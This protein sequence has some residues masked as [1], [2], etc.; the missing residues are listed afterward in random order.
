[1]SQSVL[2][3]YSRLRAVLLLCPAALVIYTASGCGHSQATTARG[4][5]SH[6]IPVRSFPVAEQKVRRRVQ[7]VGSLFA[8][9]ESTISAQVEGRIARVLV[10][11]GDTVKQGQ[12]MVE[13]DPV[14]LQYALEQQR[15]QVNQMRAQLG[16]GP[17]DPPPKDPGKV[18][19]VQRAAADLFDAEQKFHRAQQMFHDTLISQQQLD[20]AST[21]DQGAKAAYALALQDVDR[22]KAQLQSGQAGTQLAEKKLSDAS[23]R[24][25]F[26]GAVKARSVSPGEYLRVQSPVMVVVRTDKLRA[27]LAVPERWAGTVK[28]GAMIDV[29]VEAFPNEVFRG[30]L[31][32]MNPAV[33]QDS[34]TFD[35]EALLA[36]PGARLKPGFFVQASMPSEVEERTLTV[37]EQAVTY[38]YGTYKVFVL[39]GS[40]VSERSIKPGAQNDDGGIRRIEI[41]EGLTARDRVAVAIEGDLR[42]GAAVRDQGA[43]NGATDVK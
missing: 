24:A 41:V 2:H 11:V 37:P 33:T 26:Q 15:A 7:A 40:R 27:R 39:N 22:L 19:F 6:P 31:E 20:E 43:G 36:N 25:P 14:E 5:A 34:R 18:A 42:D 12:V 8:W 30:K 16:I 38:R 17:N 3:F 35:V 21:H 28:I 4:D 29:Q 9:D 1:L 23:I 13:I 10:D 32:R